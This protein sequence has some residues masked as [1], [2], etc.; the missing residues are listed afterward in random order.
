MRTVRA[1]SMTR[2]KITYGGTGKDR[3]GA[4]A[5]GD[6]PATIVR[7]GNSAKRSMD[8]RMWPITSG[9]FCGE[10]FCDVLEDLFQIGCHALR[11]ENAIWFAHCAIQPMPYFLRFRA[12]NLLKSSNSPR[13]ISASA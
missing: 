13:S 12:A 3:T 4:L 8:L 6:C 11:K 2:K 9:A 10:R 7:W 5:S 1:C